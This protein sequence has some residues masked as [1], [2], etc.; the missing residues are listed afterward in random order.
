MHRGRCFGAAPERG[1]AAVARPAAARASRA[2]AAPSGGRARPPAGLLDDAR[3]RAFGRDRPER[4]RARAHPA[5]ASPRRAAPP[6]D[7]RDAGALAPSTPRP[8]G[9][10][11]RRTRTPRALARTRSAAQSTRCSARRA[12]PSAH[13][14]VRRAAAGCAA[15]L[16][17]TRRR[18]AS[19]ATSRRGSAAGAGGRGR[20]LVERT[21][22]IRTCL[23][24][25]CDETQR[26]NGEAASSSR[27][28]VSESARSPGSLTGKKRPR[29]P[30]RGTSR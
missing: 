19:P 28:A 22:G 26:W 12:K 7:A 8:G 14:T 9:V 10:P 27:K 1:R 21:A 3:A 23:C 25:L 17:C 11:H 6:P 20:T 15:A 24:R 4:G 18:A 30:V 2:P 5:S 29:G 16:P 13:R